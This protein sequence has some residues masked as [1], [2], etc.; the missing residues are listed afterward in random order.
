MSIVSVCLMGIGV[1]FAGLICLIVICYIMSAICR[2][3]AKD[4]ENKTDTPPAQSIPTPAAA[5]PNKQ[6]MVAAIA[7]TVAEDLGA[8]VSALRILSIKKI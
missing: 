7:A 1:V 3:T 8:D 4:A 6:E 2:S 5:I